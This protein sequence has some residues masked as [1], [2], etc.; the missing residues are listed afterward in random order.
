MFEDRT[1]FALSSRHKGAP[2]P[3][4]AGI[5]VEGRLDAVLL[6]LT[7]RQTY[8]NTGADLM[9]VVYTFPLPAMAVLLGVAS[10]LNGD[11]KE[12]VVVARR[13]AE[14]QY[15]Q[16]LQAG[17]AP[18]MLES[19]GNG[20]HSAN[21]GNLKPG[22][23]IVVEVRLA[24]VLEFEQGRV[25]VSI[26]TTI[27]PRYG[28]ASAA[29]LQAQ[30][31]PLSGLDV[32][33][34]LELSLT[35]GGALAGADLACPS[36][37]TEIT[38]DEGGITRMVLS[39][40][41]RLDRDVVVILTPREPRP[42]LLI[43][44]DDPVDPTA[45]VV[46]MA[47][48][49]PPA[50]APRERIALKL[51]V[52]CSG[53]MNGDSI[54]SVRSA[55]RGVV[56]GLFEQDEVSLS[57]FGSIIEHTV[58]PCLA[59]SQA[60]ARLHSVIDS[61]QADLGGTHTEA[62][63]TSV[64][65]LPG[66]AEAGVADVLLITDGLTWHTKTLVAAAQASGHRV[67]C[68]GVGSAPAESFLRE[69]AAATRGA[70][71]FAAPGEALEAAAQRMVERIRQPVFTNVRV[72]WGHTPT[73]SLDP[74][75]GLFGGD[76]VVAMAGFS[77]PLQT[78]GAT[79]LG[80]DA[81]H[82][83][84]ELARTQA[85]APSPG[86]ALSKVAAWRRI[87]LLGEGQAVDSALRYQLLTR[88]THCILVHER[89]DADRST[90]QAELHRV[91]SMLA[92]GWAGLSR[93]A[94][95]DVPECSFATF[96]TVPLASQRP[97]AHAP[98]K[99]MDSG[100]SRPMF[101]QGDHFAA[102]TAAPAATAARATTSE[103]EALESLARLV[104]G[105][106][107]HDAGLQDLAQAMEGVALFPALQQAL[108]D[109]A[110]LNLSLGECWLLLAD[111]INA[112]LHGLADAQLSALLHPLLMKLDPAQLVRAS[113]VFDRELGQYSNDSWSSAREKRLYHAMAGAGTR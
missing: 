111:W 88:H 5:H 41:A 7:L 42:N 30:Q 64:W 83:V 77:H 1:H 55:L 48:L 85:L 84:V 10:E 26:P 21:I 87:P 93:V 82:Q 81:Q 33:Y 110:K 43:Q 59:S 75:G 13:Q 95:L 18:V 79:L 39:P 91:K 102:C 6:S 113:E 74:T 49:Q 20:L 92:A 28:N 61:L 14:R 17:D 40:S 107:S 34:P 78:R 97:P 67:F 51:L 108:D 2:A 112:R 62:A 44:A 16:S 105:H 46:L 57:R 24:Q 22:D 73:W 70:C 76:T 12:G 90:Q 45:P 11:R 4:L 38:R 54:G 65:K 8:R 89:A 104:R 9:E 47:A 72:D 69:L 25:R 80:E 31:V 36:H 37:G 23:E 60:L 56:A 68:I 101:P 66:V 29:G 27:A 86:D 63:L 35:I 109:V 15:E 19:N 100:Q 53:S 103:L 96:G 58:Q 52:D 32:E 99:V 50:G 94:A 98:S 3:V 106:L 71:E